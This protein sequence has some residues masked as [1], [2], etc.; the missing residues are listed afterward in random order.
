MYEANEA[1][2]PFWGAETKTKGGRDPLAVQNSS[3]VIYSDMITG[4]TNVTGRVRYNGFFCW[5]LTFIAK[6]IAS[7]DITKID[8]PAEQIRLIRRGEL[9]LAYINRNVNGV[10]GGEFTGKYFDNDIIDLAWGADYENKSVHKIYWQNSMGIFGQY[11]LG[12]LL[13]LRLVYAPTPGG[14]HKSYRVTQVGRKLAE[15]FGQ[16]LTENIKDLFWEGIYS[17]KIA[18]EKLPL[19]SVMALD[20]IDNENELDEYLRIFR[21]PDRQDFTG[22]DICHRINSIRLLLEYIKEKGHETPSKGFVLSFLR[23]NFE[24]VLGNINSAHDEQIAWFL[25]ELNELAHTAYEAFHFAILYS[26]SEEPQPLDN[27]LSG[28]KDEYDNYSHDSIDTDDIY[29]LYY[30]ILRC[31]KEKSYGELLYVATHLLIVLYKTIEPHLET[32][33]KFAQHES[34]DI[35]HPGFAPT[36]LI[37]LVDKTENADWD[38]VENILYTAINDHL[39][40]SYGKST[41][42]QGLVH[43][44][45]VDDGLIWKLRELRPG[46]TSPRLQNVLQ[47]IEDMKWI[48]RSDEYYTID[49][50]GLSILNDD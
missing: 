3:V 45:M 16:S 29:S 35:M 36:L 44:Y 11:Y 33:I 9:L 6:R 48:K 26:I 22:T 50:R 13:Q 40:S 37:R 34:Y 47:Y 24:T 43:N 15:T 23:Y 25:Y 38:F 21:Q 30:H 5:L 7:I 27:S 4:I 10:S 2:F 46:R 32:L 12:A 14:S 8:S 17:G 20:K 49:T 28:L 19:M 42:G 31:Y 41:I 18:T 1:P 39:R